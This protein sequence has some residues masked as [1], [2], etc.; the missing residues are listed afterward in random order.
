MSYFLRSQSTDFKTFFIT[1]KFK[2]I[3]I[4]YNTH[5]HMEDIEKGYFYS[6]NN[7]YRAKM[8]MKSIVYDSS[9]AEHKRLL[10]NLKFKQKDTVFVYD[11]DPESGATAQTVSAGKIKY[12]KSDS[13]LIFYDVKDIESHSTKKLYNP[14]MSVRKFKVM[15]M[16]NDKFILLDKD[17]TDVKRTYIFK[18][19][20]K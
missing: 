4:R 15:K 8:E 10:K 5:S 18:K 13:T 17:F 7:K 3:D 9:K 1:N 12:N 2:L 6:E 20:I 16:E 14:F 19:E 11:W